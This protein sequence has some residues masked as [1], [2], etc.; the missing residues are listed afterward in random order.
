MYQSGYD[1]GVN[2][3]N[4]ASYDDGYDEGFESG[5]LYGQESVHSFIT[6][7]EKAQ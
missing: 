7:K 3:P 1:D 2:E 4:Q 5:K 6:L